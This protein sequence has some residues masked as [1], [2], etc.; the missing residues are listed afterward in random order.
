MTTMNP[1]AALPEYD[2]IPGPLW[3]IVILHLLTLTLH[4]LAMNF[5]LGGMVV[6]LFG[7]IENRWQNPVVQ[8]YI[9]LF[10]TLMAATVT[11]AIAPLLFTQLTYG[12]PVYS[13][14]IVS[15]WWWL[16]VPLVVIVGYYFLYGS[17]FAKAGN[18][19]VRIWLFV[20]LLCLVYVSLVQSSVFSLAERPDVQQAVYEKDQSGLALNPNVGEWIWRWL[21]M[22]T[23]AVTVGSFLIGVLG[24]DDEQVFGAAKKAMLFGLIL[25]SITGVLYLLNLGDYLKPFMRSAGIWT[26]TIGIVLALGQ[27]HFFFRKKFWGAG[28]M[29]FGSLATMVY[30]RH[31]LRLVVLPEELR[32]ANVYA[33]KVAPQWDVFGLFLVCFLVAIGLVWW[34]LKTF[35]TDRGGETAEA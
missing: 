18:P 15:G 9:K 30:T 26:M 24:R 32:P 34:M 2:T 14:T 20:A 28:A 10:P 22:L 25:A 27:L 11:L 31:A 21:H 16:L 35:F 13:A 29:I 12:G 7:K 6:V 19:K 23:G 8:R 17:A 3:L 5:M 4:F 33:D 1:L